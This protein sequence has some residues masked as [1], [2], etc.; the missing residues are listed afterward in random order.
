MTANQLES[1]T[2]SQNN[3]VTI[4]ASYGEHFS[5]NARKCRICRIGSWTVSSGGKYTPKMHPKGSPRAATVS[6]TDEEIQ[7]ASTISVFL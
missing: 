4:K 6:F 5:K 3:V 1:T 2:R 7:D